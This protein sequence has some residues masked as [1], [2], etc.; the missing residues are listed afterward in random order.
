[1]L[2]YSQPLQF[3]IRLYW[4]LTLP[5]L[6]MLQGRSA[7]RWSLC[8]PGWFWCSTWREQRTARDA[9]SVWWSQSSCRRRREKCWGVRWGRKPPTVYSP[10][11]T[12][13]P[14][15]KQHNL[16]TERE[17][18]REKER[19]VCYKSA[20]SE[21]IRNRKTSWWLTTGCFWGFES[22]QDLGERDRKFVVNRVTKYVLHM[23]V[24]K[25]VL[26]KNNKTTRTVTTNSLSQI[27]EGNLSAVC[28]GHKD[29][30]YKWVYVYV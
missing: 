14:H 29:R 27:S 17:R 7:G 26:K 1:M 19:Q 13:P 22:F 3:D 16:H 30:E 25:Q 28:K 8:S 24:L 9:A 15:G 12:L 21:L 6:L 20:Q 18:Q 11:E 10:T 2:Q 4:Y 5:R 23:T